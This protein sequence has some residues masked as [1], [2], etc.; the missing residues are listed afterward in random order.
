MKS[1]SRATGRLVDLNET[2]NIVSDGYAHRSA[3][4]GQKTLFSNNI[5]LNQCQESEH[6]AGRQDPYRMDLYL[7]TKGRLEDKGVKLKT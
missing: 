7:K 5:W 2:Q 1:R 6:E 4:Q 3:F